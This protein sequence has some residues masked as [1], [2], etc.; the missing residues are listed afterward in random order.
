M[1][2]P[3]WSLKLHELLNL[4]LRESQLDHPI[5]ATKERRRHT[6]KPRIQRLHMSL[7]LSYHFLK[8]H[9]LK[10]LEVAVLLDAV[11]QQV[12]QIAS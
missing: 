3:F 4:F 6:F 8:L 1:P 9:G 5:E 12:P 2:T 11:N 10:L 7:Y